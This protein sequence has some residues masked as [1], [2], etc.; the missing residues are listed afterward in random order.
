M[1][2]KVL[3]HKETKDF[4]HIE[5]FGDNYEVLTSSLP[6]IFPMSATIELMKEIYPPD[7]SDFD[8]KKIEL[9]EFELIEF[10]EVGADI[11]N[12][13]T[14][15]KTL[16]ALLEMYFKVKIAHASEERTELVEIIKKEMEQ[17]KISIEYIA[18]LL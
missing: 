14:P 17:T 8:F 18:D 9:I 10:G 2:V 1:K 5:R 13:L 15:P 12:K 3:R 4:I 11:R 6:K 7:Y 16:V